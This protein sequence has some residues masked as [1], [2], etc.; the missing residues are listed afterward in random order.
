MKKIFIF[1]LEVIFLDGS[2]SAV[3]TNAFSTLRKAR[4]MLNKTFK[5]LS[6]GIDNVKITNDSYSIMGNKCSMNGTIKEVVL[7]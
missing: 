6:C 1:T 4:R 2:G 3:N 5:T 7:N